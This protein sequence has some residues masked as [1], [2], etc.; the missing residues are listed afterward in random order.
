MKRYADCEALR[1]SLGRAIALL[2]DGWVDH[3]DCWEVLERAETV[4]EAPDWTAAAAWEARAIVNYVR[5]YQ[6]RGAAA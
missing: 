4:A 2:S 1:R 5:T 6:E 3:P